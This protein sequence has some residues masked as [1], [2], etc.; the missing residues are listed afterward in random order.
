M[1]DFSRCTT[2]PN[3]QLLLL[4]RSDSVIYYFKACGQ[5][6][7]LTTMRV[8]DHGTLSE[9]FYELIFIMAPTVHN[10]TFRCQ[11]SLWPLTCSCIL[12][13]LSCAPQKCVFEICDALTCKYRRYRMSKQV[14]QILTGTES[15]LFM[16]LTNVY[17]KTV[18]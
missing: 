16:P 9:Y 2:P 8:Q 14:D 10:M 17:N 3:V 6:P 7:I 12:A 4:F 15:R 13:A 11:L 5:W 18:Q 1:P